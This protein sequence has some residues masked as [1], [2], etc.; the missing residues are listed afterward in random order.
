MTKIMK[1]D[2]GGDRGSIWIDADEVAEEKRV[3]RSTKKSSGREEVAF[4][5]EA[6]ATLASPFEQFIIG[7]CSDEF[8]MRV[9]IVRQTS[10]ARGSRL[11]LEARSKIGNCD[12]PLTA[13]SRAK[14]KRDMLVP[15]DQ[16]AF[17]SSNSAN[18]YCTYERPNGG[19]VMGKI[20]KLD[21]GDDRGSI[22]IEADEVPEE[23]RVRRS[24]KKSS[25]REEVAL[26]A[27][28]V[29]TLASAFEQ[30]TQ[31]FEVAQAQ[32][33]EL[34]RKAETSIELNAK[35]STKGNL[36]IVQGSAEASIKVTMKWSAPKDGLG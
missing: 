8:G 15:G 32:L 14:D 23:K 18:H 3:W 11:Y 21:L 12:A 10:R 30:F 25:G 4:G 24:T 6:V 29:A 20:M 34:A 36:I 13:I 31:I 27:E 33:S 17:F 26:G 16:H 35:L 22:W 1:I 7:H 5:A 2:R 19:D 9:K 28:T